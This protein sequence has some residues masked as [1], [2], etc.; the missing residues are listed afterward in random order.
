MSRNKKV[1]VVD[2]NPIN[3]AIME[4]ILAAH[5]DLYFADNGLDAVRAAIRYRPAAVMLDVMMPDMDGLEVC[6][7]IRKSIKGASPIIVMVSAKAMPSEQ[8]A[9]LNAG[10]NGYLTKPFDETELLATLQLH[11]NRDLNAMP[12]GSK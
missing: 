8:L 1:L 2:D 12:A 3:S 9:G 6:R 7:L 4:E 10:A 11:L 5:Y